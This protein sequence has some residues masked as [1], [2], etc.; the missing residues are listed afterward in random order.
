[1]HR[2]LDTNATNLLPTNVVSSGMLPCF[3]R[4]SQWC[5]IVH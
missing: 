1:M 4:K 3:A 2:H 5:K